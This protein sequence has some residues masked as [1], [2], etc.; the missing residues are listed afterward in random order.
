MRLGLSLLG[1]PDL[2][3]I[4]PV[5][6]LGESTLQQLGLQLKKCWKNDTIAGF[7]LVLSSKGKNKELGIFVRKVYLT[8]IRIAEG[9]F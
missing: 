9:F 1:Y 6:A 8:F 5:Y 3:P 2:H 7:Y 4:D